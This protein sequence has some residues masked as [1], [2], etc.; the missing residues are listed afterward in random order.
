MT[1]TQGRMDDQWRRRIEQALLEALLTKKPANV[2]V[3]V[4]LR[5]GT[6]M[7]AYLFVDQLN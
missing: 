7:S 3:P 6:R 4:V 2:R 1:V 5:D